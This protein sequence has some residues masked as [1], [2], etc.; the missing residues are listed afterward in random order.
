M[1]TTIGKLK[2]MLTADTRKYSQS[3]HGANRTTKNFSKSMGGVGAAAKRL[4]PQL[5]AVASVTGAIGLAVRGITSQLSRLDDVAKTAAK[6]GTTTEELSRLQFAASKTGVEANTLNMALQRMTRR[7]SE[8]AGGTGEAKDAIQELGLSAIDL[9]RKGP[10]Q[11]IYAIAD[12]LKLVPN[13]ADRVRLAMKLFDSEGVALVNTLQGGSAALREFARQSDELGNT[14]DGKAAKAAERFNDTVT[15]LKASLGGVFAD[16]IPAVTPIMETFVVALTKVAKAINRISEAAKKNEKWLKLAAVALGGAVG[17]AAVTA[18]EAGES[19][20]SNS[21]SA[22]TVMSPD[23][24]RELRFVKLS[25]AQSGLTRGFAE[26][27]FELVKNIDQIKALNKYGRELTDS[28]G[29]SGQ[30]PAAEMLKGVGG[31]LDEINLAMREMDLRAARIFEQTRTPAEKLAA[32][33]QEI[34][35]LSVGGFLD[36]D[37]AR[38]AIAQL[39]NNDRRSATATMAGGL[40]ERVSFAAIGAAQ[41]TGRKTDAM[42]RLQKQQA[43]SDRRREETQR[44]TL[45]VIRGLTTEQKIKVVSF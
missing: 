26:M 21:P 43:E 22:A 27:G 32:Q 19:R 4:V 37:T 40:G 6:I 15:D 35:E 5:A 18:Y 42:L 17:A 7:I 25:R 12:A 8:A 9:E 36:E 10:K 34:Q 1:A 38:R 13:Q 31:G 23:F 3:L 41:A 16:L 39:Q 14:V 30:H 44:K 20:G 2:V 29:G 28:F 33:L 45:G 11:A 24:E